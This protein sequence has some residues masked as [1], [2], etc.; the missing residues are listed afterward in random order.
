MALLDSEL[1]RIRFE[2]GWNLLNVG[3]EPYIGVAAIFSQVIQPYLRSGAITTSSTAVTAASEATPVTL[4]LASAIGFSAQCRVVVDVD[5]AQEA[6]TV[7]SL[8]GSNITLALKN[9]HTGA[10]AVTVEGG[11]SIVRELLGQ[12]RAVRVQMGQT[13]GEGALKKVDEVEFYDVK[14]TQARFGMLGDQLMYWRDELCSAL[15]ISNG[16]RQKRSTG[17]RMSLY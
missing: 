13:F 7:Q 2:T 9:A 1:D 4:T 5:D 16:W 17:S 14:G 12:I 3:A 6:A 11:E 15:G 10:Y 8:S